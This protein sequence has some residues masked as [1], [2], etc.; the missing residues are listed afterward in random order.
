MAVSKS[1]N[2]A[3]SVRDIRALSSAELMSVLYLVC[4]CA[5]VG[6]VHEG[7]VERRK[8]ATSSHSL[9]SRQAV[10]LVTTALAAIP[11][12]LDHKAGALLA[13]SQNHGEV[14]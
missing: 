2:T 1:V 14:E 12:K 7:E 10:K 8:K 13:W 5:G 4:N 3:C 11:V 9:G 6:V